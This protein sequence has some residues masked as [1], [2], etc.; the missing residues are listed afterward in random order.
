MIRSE[1]GEE[2][3]KGCDEEGCGGFEGDMV[4]ALIESTGVRKMV[5]FE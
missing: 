4:E 5:S 2:W 3:Q 1:W